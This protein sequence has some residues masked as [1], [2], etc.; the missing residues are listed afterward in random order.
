M[1]EMRITVVAVIALF[2]VIS[3]TYAVKKLRADNI[4]EQTASSDFKTTGTGCSCC[5][6]GAQDTSIEGIQK[7]AANYYMNMYRDRDFSVTVKD[8]GCH[9]EAYIIKNGNTVKT[10]SI[11]GGKVYEIG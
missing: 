9:Q 10:L 4:P 3:T 11:S 2:L 7:Q 8:F 6:S 1:N 5:G